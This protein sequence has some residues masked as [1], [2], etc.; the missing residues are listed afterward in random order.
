MA[1]LEVNN[2]NVYY[3]SIHAVKDISFKVEKGEIISLIGANG[4]G[5]TTILQTV[6]GLLKSNTGSQDCGTRIGTGT[7]GTSRVFTDVRYGKS[8]ARCLHPAEE[9][10]RSES[11]NR[12]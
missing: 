7:G 8:G 6:S 2:I 4:A 3:G 10:H 12:V 11:G 9:Y 5:K 1:M